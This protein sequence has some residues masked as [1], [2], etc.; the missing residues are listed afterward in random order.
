MLGRINK[1][2][3]KIRSVIW[4]M[5]VKRMCAESGEALKVNGRSYVTSKTYLGNHVNL[6][7]MRIFGG[8]KVCIG[9]YFH[10]GVEC[11]II[12]QNHNYDFGK[13]IPYDNT[14]IMKDVVIE[15]NVWLGSRVTILP[16][17][18]IREGAIVQAG[19]V[20]TKDIPYCGIAGG[21]PAKVFKY[22][23]I[24]HYERLKSEGKYF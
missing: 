21:S 22:R 13:T 12:T 20:V 7:G 14:Y 8:G 19:A 5:R 4:T 24:K 17:V 11:M 9:D 1:L 3:K 10:S 16:G 18:R 23:D 2:R 6:N 15:D